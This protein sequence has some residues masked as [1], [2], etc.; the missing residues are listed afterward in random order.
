MKPCPRCGQ[1]MSIGK[2]ISRCSSCCYRTFTRILMQQTAA[3]K[4]EADKAV[5]KVSEDAILMD[6]EDLPF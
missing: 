2:T 1:P 3:E 5:N 6:E 4:A